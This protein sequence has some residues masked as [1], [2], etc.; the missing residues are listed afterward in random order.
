MFIIIIIIIIII[1]VIIIIIII[2]IVSACGRMRFWQY[3]D[4]VVLLSHHMV[5]VGAS[6][7]LCVGVVL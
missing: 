3:T 7:C 1:V 4:I 5:I 2:I 6:F